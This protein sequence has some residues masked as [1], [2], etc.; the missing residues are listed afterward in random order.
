MP[1]GEPFVVRKHDGK[2]YRFRKLT[3]YC[4]QE[5]VR[6]YRGPQRDKLKAELIELK[7]ETPQLITTLQDFDRKS[8]ELAMVMDAADSSD[9]RT[10]LFELSLCDFS[11]PAPGQPKWDLRPDATSCVNY[12][13]TLQPT[14][15]ADLVR[16]ICGLPPIDRTKDDTTEDEPDPTTPTEQTTPPA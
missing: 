11:L 5:L 8:Q 14:E 2:E 13:S 9:G 3:P 10:A 6:R 12:I 15:V 4:R 7:V 16:D 1:V